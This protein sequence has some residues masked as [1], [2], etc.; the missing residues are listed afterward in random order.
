LRAGEISAAG[1]RRPEAEKGGASMSKHL[2][3]SCG[4]AVRYSKRSGPWVFERPCPWC[5]GKLVGPVKRPST[6]G[7]RFLPCP[8]CGVSK[9]DGKPCVH[10]YQDEI[11]AAI[12]AKEQEG[13]AA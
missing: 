11:A 5:G 2:C 12:A 1:G 4:K 7:R 9:L 6:E 13:G 3:E 10:H 8:V